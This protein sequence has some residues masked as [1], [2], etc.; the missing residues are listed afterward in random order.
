LL[1]L[2]EDLRL[3]N[4][5][6][7]LDTLKAITISINDNGDPS[8]I[9]D[10]LE[11]RLTASESKDFKKYHD[12]TTPYINNKFVCK[13]EKC[14]NSQKSFIPI[15][16]LSILG[17][18]P[19]DK[20]YLHDEVFTLSYYSE[21]GFTQ[22]NVYN[23]PVSIRKYYINKLVEAKKKEKDQVDKVNTPSTDTNPKVSKPNIS[24]NRKK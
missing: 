18:E 11:N 21:G 12:L 5:Y 13:C 16:N 23:L 7:W 6:T 4:E 17:L 24:N 8:I 9:P 22:D 20:S 3:P 2:G 15:N 14:E 10:F 1:T 19:K